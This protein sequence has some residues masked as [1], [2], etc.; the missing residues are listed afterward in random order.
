MEMH[1]LRYFLAVADLGGFTRAAGQCHV[2]QPSLSVQLAKL[3][4]ELG[5]ALFE[6]GRRAARL[7]ARGES[8][9]PRA[10][11][12][13]AELEAGRRELE[14]LAG[15]SRGSVTFGCLPTTGAHLLPRILTAFKKKHPSVTVRLREESSPG[16]GACLAKGEVDLAVL[17][18]AGLR[19]G[20]DAQKLF[21]EDLLL[22][23][24]PDHAL[25]G[26]KKVSL[27]QVGQDNVILM[28][29][30]H[31]FR[32]IT[33]AAFQKAGVVPR[34]VFESGEIGT[35]QALVAAGLGV[36]LV[37][38]MVKM[39]KGGPAYVE[40]DK[41]APG[42]TLYLATRKRGALSPAAKA[43][44]DVVISIIGQRDEG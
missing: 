42:R 36:S 30:G 38:R 26:R 17:D 31:G 10:R 40:M 32:Q 7:T 6:R 25:A 21:S 20:L 28:K 15:L 39:E 23:L 29:Q 22:A 12:A 11:V 33:L 8:F 19:P 1:Q 3:E 44:K 34:V 27:S 14:E 43:L 5:G 24:P 4:A 37:P 41:P 16:L 9:L 2:S 18:D 13:L 35:I